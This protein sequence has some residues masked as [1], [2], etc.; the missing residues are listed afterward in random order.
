[1]SNKLIANAVNGVIFDKV[2]NGDSFTAYDVTVEVRNIVGRGVNVAHD[3]VK[4]LVHAAFLSGKMNGYDR[5]LDLKV[6]APVPPYRYS[7]VKPPAQVAAPA[8][9]YSNPTN[10]PILNAFGGTPAPAPVSNPAPVSSPR[11]NQASAQSS[12]VSRSG[13]TLRLLKDVLNKGGFRPGDKVHVTYLPSTK[14]IF[15]TGSPVRRT[16]DPLA[17]TKAHT[18][19]VKQNVRVNLSVLGAQ[20]NTSFIAVPKN[21]QI[22]IA[23]G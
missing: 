18:V 13:N 19:D 23:C 3:D 9:T 6:N 4:A 10:N 17:V 14:Q 8:K 2:S 7:Q 1:M 21:G 5:A 20:K 15:V 12:V 22:E 16:S 11:A